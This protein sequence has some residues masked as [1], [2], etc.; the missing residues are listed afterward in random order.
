MA[1]YANTSSY[2]R[3]QRARRSRFRKR[4]R[5][6]FS[7]KKTVKRILNKTT[8]TKYYDLAS[9]NEQL[10]HNVG[11]SA[12]ALVPT[13][14]YSDP[15]FFNP[16]AD[17]PPGTGRANRVGDK[18]T[19]ISMNLKI[20]LSNKKDRFNL[21][22]R[23]IIARMPKAI[24]AALTTSSNIYIFQAA[25]LGAT[26]NTMVLPIDHDKGIKPYYDRIHRINNFTN[27]V[28]AAS[29]KEMSKI[30]KIKIKRKKA[31]TI[32]YDSVSQNIVNSPLALYIIPYDSYGTLVTDNV[33]SYSFHTRMYYKDT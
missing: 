2:R 17:I 3:S 24:G 4:T 6:K 16:W 26:G 22:Y 1:R 14:Q 12:G 23:I 11:R 7:L 15:T 21:N 10:Y 33:A 31:N 13:T 30:V 20:W 27:W 28:D 29:Q 25:Q 9:E 19:P 8:E 18:I 5:G 32:I